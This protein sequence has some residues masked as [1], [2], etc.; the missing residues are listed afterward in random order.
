MA[1]SKDVAWTATDW[2]A[3]EL[4][5]ESRLV[6]EFSVQLQN[7]RLG[8][9]VGWRDSLGLGWLRGRNAILGNRDRQDYVE[10]LERVNEVDLRRFLV[11]ND[12][13]MHRAAQNMLN[14]HRS[15]LH[16]LQ[17]EA[18]RADAIAEARCAGIGF[19]LPNNG[20][21]KFGHPVLIFNAK[22]HDPQRFHAEI[23]AA[24]VALE[25][26]AALRSIPPGQTVAKI[27]LI[28]YLPG[29]TPIDVSTYSKVIAKL[30]EAFPER[31]WRC[32]ICPCGEKTPWLFALVRPFLSEVTRRKLVFVAP[33]AWGK[34]PARE[35]MLHY[36]DAEVLPETLGGNFAWW[37]EG[38]AGRKP[39]WNI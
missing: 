2:S 33:G 6:E 16:A 23:V 34:A 31:L 15:Q 30:T 19:R 12:M 10:I 5:V 37:P 39:C 17:V 27:L 7:G 4:E 26:I 25:G 24:L 28:A 38:V 13:V 22:A 8:Q 11:A 29:G 14:A 9:E 20:T 21:D 1:A 3:E 35:E 18:D 32:L 36:L